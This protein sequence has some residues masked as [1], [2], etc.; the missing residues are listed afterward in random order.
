LIKKKRGSVHYI[1]IVAIVAVVAIIVL[2][3]NNIQ[4][5]DETLAGEA[6]RFFGI[7]KSIPTGNMALMEK[8]FESMGYKKLDTRGKL[9][10][11]LDSYVINKKI[12]KEIWKEARNKKVWEYTKNKNRNV[13]LRKK[14]LKILSKPKLN[15][16]DIYKANKMTEGIVNSLDYFDKSNVFRDAYLIMAERE[17]RDYYGARNGVIWNWEKA[18]NSQVSII[19]PVI[20][21]SYGGDLSFGA[22]PS[23]ILPEKDKESDEGERQGEGGFGSPSNGGSLLGEINYGMYQ[24]LAP[25][26]YGDGAGPAPAGGGSASQPGSVVGTTTPDEGGAKIDPMLSTSPVQPT[27]KPAFEDCL[28]SG[29]KEEGSAGDVDDAEADEEKAAE[30]KKKNEQAEEATKNKD[31]TNADEEDTDSD[32]GTVK[33]VYNFDSKTKS[34]YA[35]ITMDLGGGVKLSKVGGGGLSPEGIKG[36]GV[37]GLSFEKDG[38]T[39]TTGLFTAVEINFN[40]NSDFWGGV[41]LNIEW[42]PDPS[43][44]SPGATIPDACSDM[45]CLIGAIDTPG[46]EEISKFLECSLDFEPELGVGVGPVALPSENHL[47]GCGAESGLTAQYIS[48]SAEGFTDPPL[49]GNIEYLLVF[50]TPGSESAK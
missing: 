43:G 5:S 2:I 9:Y 31:G 12:H 29:L 7:Q 33:L 34:G 44:D 36:S 17:L 47:A 13:Q 20:G 37:G 45:P 16:R 24:G 23:S 41:G 30:E 35:K 8:S 28:N 6:R 18:M 25:C 42:M 19:V 21:G 48:E 27:E 46:A 14:V 26:M 39:Y 1:A 4:T 3:L 11:I 15:S 40:G 50:S 49:N 38:V 32:T 10:A 22:D